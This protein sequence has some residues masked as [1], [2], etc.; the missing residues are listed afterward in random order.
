M[1]DLMIYPDAGQAESAAARII[2]EQVRKKPGS[3]LGLATGKTMINI[4]DIL[5][6]WENE[7]EVSFSSV[8]TFNLDEYLGVAPENRDSFHSYMR[9]SFFMQLQ[10]KPAEV[11]ILDGS[12]PDPELECR[13]FERRIK[14]SGGIDLQILG[15]GRN[16]HIGFN[17]PGSPFGSRTR[18]I[19]LS[20]STRLYYMKNLLELREVPGQALTMGIATILEAREI[21]LVVT[22]A[23]KAD[24]FHK[25]INGP[26]DVD[27][28]GTALSGHHCVKVIADQAAAQKLHGHDIKVLKFKRATRP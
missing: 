23:A 7:G 22:G 11:H 19:D 25:V 26:V 4:Y 17:E 14:E 13:E 18:V 16:G 27:V 8:K 9:R 1:Y 24:A 10:K 20:E 3:V 28:P 6:K 5:W 2:I 21:V 15:L 12:A